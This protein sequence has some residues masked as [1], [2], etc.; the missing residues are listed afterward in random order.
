MPDLESRLSCQ[1][2]RG[3]TI[4]GGVGL[5]SH[6]AGDEVGPSGLV[7]PQQEMR[8]YADGV[9]PFREL[10]ADQICLLAVCGEA[11]DADR[12][13]WLGVAGEAVAD[14]PPDQLLVSGGGRHVHAG[15]GKI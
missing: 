11:D 10:A 1:A 14:G 13:A 5:E 12:G 7:G 4:P 2:P 9:E 8:V 15:D 6:V 3:D